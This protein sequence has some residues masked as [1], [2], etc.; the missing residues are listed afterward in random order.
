V[1]LA[2]KEID[3]DSLSLEGLEGLLDQIFGPEEGE[4]FCSQ[5]AATQTGGHM[6]LDA[7]ETE[8]T[9]AGVC[10]TLPD[11]KVSRHKTVRDIR[12]PK[13]EQ[14]LL[15]QIK[16][17]RARLHFALEQLEHARLTEASLRLSL[18]HAQ[19]QLKQHCESRP[20]NASE[21]PLLLGSDL[22]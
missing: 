8:Q 5:V 12:H 13:Q 4:Q 3:L 7:R 22:I 9:S 15:N 10:A 1:S 20:D 2:K 6:R 18:A 21:S 11:T 14:V 19:D 16:I 17:L